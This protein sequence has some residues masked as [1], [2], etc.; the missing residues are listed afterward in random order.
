[1]ITSVLRSVNAN[2][3]V[4][5]VRATRG[6]FTRA[7]PVAAL[8]ERGLIKHVGALRDLESQLATWK[9]G[10]ASPDRLDALVWAFTELF[11]QEETAPAQSFQY[12]YTE[13]NNRRRR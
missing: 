13:Q 12:S 8:Y 9:P 11:L 3:P 5:L 7:E 4:K 10:D 6:K 2:V 1:M